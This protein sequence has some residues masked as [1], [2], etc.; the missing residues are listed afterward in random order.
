MATSQRVTAYFENGHL[1]P[2]TPLQGIPEHSVVNVTVDVKDNSAR[3]STE[4]QLAMLRAVPVAEELADAI[5]AG[6]TR[7]WNVEEF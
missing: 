7:A 2:L 3:F 4:E 5:E 1:T 6:R